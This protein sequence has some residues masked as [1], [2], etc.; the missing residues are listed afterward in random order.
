[1][2]VNGNT[3]N[4]LIEGIGLGEGVEVISIESNAFKGNK[5]HLRDYR[6]EPDFDLLES[7]LTANT[8]DQAVVVRGSDIKVPAIFESIQDAIDAAAEGNMIEVSPGTYRENIVVNKNGLKIK[9]AVEHD[10]VIKPDLGDIIK[11]TAANISVEGFEL[12]GSDQTGSFRGIH[13]GG[14][15]TEILKNR[16]IGNSPEAGNNSYISGTRGII[17]SGTNDN[18]LIQENY[19]AYWHTGVF[20]QAS[21]GVVIDKNT[22]ENVRSSNANDGVADI[23]YTENVYKNSWNGISFD[24]NIDGFVTI[25]DNTFDGVNNVAINI[26]GYRNGNPDNTKINNNKFL[27][28]NEFGVQ[29]TSGSLIDSTRNWWGSASGPSGEGS[30]TGDS[31]TENINFTPWLSVA[32]GETET[33]NPLDFGGSEEDI[34]SDSKTATIGDQ[35]VVGTKKVVIYAGTEGGTVTM[36]GTDTS[37]TVEFQ[38]ETEVYGPDGWD[39]SVDSP[40]EGTASGNAP[41]GFNIGGTIV[42]VGSS[43]GVLLFNKAVKIIVPNTSPPVA[44]KPAGS[45]N[46]TQITTQCIGVNDHSNISPYE[47]CYIESGDDIIIWTYHF[48]DF[49]NLREIAEVVVTGGGGGGPVSPPITYTVTGIIVGDLTGDG[50]VGILDLSIMMEN[51]GVEE[52]GNVADLNGDGKVDKYDFAILMSNWTN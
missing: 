3:F 11:I 32:S 40:S 35:N 49:G 26:R 30:G 33:S 24:A 20:N 39:G 6:V 42:T 45:N 44:Y 8:F 51:W 25:E 34:S 38:D 28:N 48:T 50:N 29:N 14:P 22:F 36:T 21:T 17:F 5:E 23:T 13:L 2:V 18:A 9:S 1:M 4:T 19:F 7:T 12:N 41:S 31:V 52:E 37:A 46:W 27:G 16:I 15:N 10:A 47:E 43:D